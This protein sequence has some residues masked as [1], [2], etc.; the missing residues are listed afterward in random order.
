MQYPTS[1]IQSTQYPTSLVQSAQFP[2]PSLQ[3]VQ[4][5]SIQPAQYP[6]PAQYPTNANGQMV[7]YVTAPSQTQQ[8]VNPVAT[9]DQQ[10]NTMSIVQPRPWSWLLPEEEVLDILNEMEQ[11]ARPTPN[12]AIPPP[13]APLTPPPA[14]QVAADASLFETVTQREAFYLRGGVLAKRLEL[15]ARARAANRGLFD[16]LRAQIRQTCTTGAVASAGQL[17]I[18]EHPGVPVPP[19]RLPPLPTPTRPR[20]PPPPLPRPPS[21]ALR[22]AARRLSQTSMLQPPRGEERRGIVGSGGERSGGR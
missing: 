7:Q 19:A 13:H 12:R 1:S 22:R 21:G 11:Q 6:A 20:S 16:A 5:P 15:D 4:Y 14:P 10:F 3:S 9:L 17:Q 8:P 18:I 2:T